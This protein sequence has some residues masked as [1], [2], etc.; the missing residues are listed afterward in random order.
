[1]GSSPSSRRQTNENNP[2]NQQRENNVRIM[3][4]ALNAALV[5]NPNMNLAYNPPPNPVKNSKTIVINNDMAIRKKTIVIEND[6]E[7]KFWLKFNY[8][9][10]FREVEIAIY[11]FFEE[12]RDLLSQI[13]KELVSGVKNSPY[14]INEFQPGKD[15]SFPRIFNLN[16]Q[17]FDEKLWIT[18][19]EDYYPLIIK[20]VFFFSFIK[21]YKNFKSQEK[22]K[23]K[24]TK[25]NV[26]III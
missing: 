17:L 1:M 2:I 12:K 19:K 14:M 18:Q 11:L 16:F 9:C 7:G 15:V 20:M 23:M 6:N 10:C 5:P 13:T 25:K 24:Q 3:N 4:E 22:K 8:D 21:N 26:F